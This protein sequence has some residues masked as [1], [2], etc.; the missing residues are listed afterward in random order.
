[1]KNRILNFPDLTRVPKASISWSR[2]RSRIVFS[3]EFQDDFDPS[4]EWLVNFVLERV[5][6]GVLSTLEET[7]SD[8]YERILGGGG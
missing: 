3:Y 5:E 6:A 7:A 8:L 2:E 4:Y 1:M